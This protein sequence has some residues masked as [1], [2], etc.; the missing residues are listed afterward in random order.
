MSR[1]LVVDD[2]EAARHAT[3][4]L[5]TRAGHEVVEAHDF[6][7]ALPILE[8]GTALDLLVVD[9]MLPEVHGFALAR[10]ARMKHPGIRCIHVT[11]YDVPTTEAVG[12]VLRKPLD[13]E[14][15][16]AE[17]TASLSTT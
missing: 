6:R 2:D 11:A 9:V 16:L 12:P 3:A 13:P 1:I 5:L 14:L 4:N 10:M 7:D 15:L 17:V 8:D